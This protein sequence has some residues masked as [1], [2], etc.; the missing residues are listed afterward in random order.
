MKRFFLSFEVLER[1][2]RFAEV[3]AETLEDAIAKIEQGVVQIQDTKPLD[4]LGWIYVD[5]SC[6]EDMVSEDET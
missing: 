1:S 3:E 2:S 4:L 5:G 6:V